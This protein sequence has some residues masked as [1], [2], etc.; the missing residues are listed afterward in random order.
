MEDIINVRTIEEEIAWQDLCAAIEAYMVEKYNATGIDEGK[1][2]SE[3]NE[4]ELK[5]LEGLV[6]Q[7]KL[8]IIGHVE[9]VALRSS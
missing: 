8:E 5:V 2:V 7:V 4:I 9:K 1:S 3:F 6:G